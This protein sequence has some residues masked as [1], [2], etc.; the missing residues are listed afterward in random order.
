MVFEAATYRKKDT[1]EFPQAESL[2]ENFSGELWI[3]AR[4]NKRW[5]RTNPLELSA[6]VKKYNAFGPS[7][8]ATSRD[9][10]VADTWLKWSF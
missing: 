3:G 6:M 8:Q 2:D 4:V 10:W 9:Y 5:G 7:V 1:K